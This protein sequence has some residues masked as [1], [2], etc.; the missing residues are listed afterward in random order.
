MD[1]F[2]SH[3]KKLRSYT[4]NLTRKVELWIFSLVSLMKKHRKTTFLVKISVYKITTIELKI[5]FQGKTNIWAIQVVSFLSYK[6]NTSIILKHLY[7]EK[8]VDLNGR[9]LL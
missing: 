4:E 5:R 7:G 6:K 8:T 3:L 2:S 1:T 9:T